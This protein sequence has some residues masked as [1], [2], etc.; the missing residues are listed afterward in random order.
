MT[1]K[2]LTRYPLF[3]LLSAQQLDDWIAS[4]Q[5]IACATGE[6]IFQENTPGAWVYLVRD[7]KVRVLRQSGQRELTLGTLHAGDVFGEY[8]L[9][10]PGRNTATCRIAA[11]SR[12]LRLPL[13]PLRTAVQGLK[14]VWK[15]LKNWLRLH[16]LLHYRRERTFLGFMSAESGLKLLDRL[17]PADFP[18]G[19]TIQAN[20]LAAS[21]WY[22]IEQGTVRLHA[23]DELETAGLDLGPGDTFGERALA[24]LG[25]LPVAMALSDV[26]C[27]VLGRHDFDPSVPIPSQVAQ[28][29]QPRL[30][31]RPA[32]HIWVPQ[33]GLADCGLAALTMVGLRR[34]AKVS[35]EELRAKVTPGPQGLSLQQLRQV[36]AE[37]GLPCQPG[38]VSVDRLGQVSLPAVAHLRGGHY[39]VLHEL[40]EGG[41]VVGDP[42]SGIVTWSLEFLAQWFSGAL[43]L[44]DLPQPS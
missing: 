19:Q 14:P 40:N 29:Y 25:E 31:A 8:G 42:E 44:F 4:G 24:G 35:V 3:R 30:P 11:P 18:A 7:G 26:R 43:L 23:G 17:Q 39:V 12:L 27:Q 1:G 21:C 41:V 38:R 22:A 10:P 9:L 20:G 36:A 6:T 16:T 37:H 34:G 2:L 15:N 33:L 32:A 13:A 5:E 28:S